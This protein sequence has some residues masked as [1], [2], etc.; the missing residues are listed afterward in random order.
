MILKPAWKLLNI[1]LPVFT[2]VL[3][4]GSNLSEL[5]EDDDEEEGERGYESDEEDEVFG[6]EGMTLHLIELLTSLVSRP[7]VMEIVKMGI[8]PLITTVS[9]YMICCKE[10]ED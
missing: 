8:L 10:L 9:S 5:R 2:E 3:G 6:V 4:Y 1:H 7:S